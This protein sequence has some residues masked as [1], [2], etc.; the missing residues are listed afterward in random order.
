MT[1]SGYLSV[2]RI[3]NG[4]TTVTVRLELRLPAELLPDGSPW[5]SFLFGPVVL[6]N[7]PGSTASEALRLPTNV[8]GMS[9]PGRFSPWP[10]RRW[11]PHLMAQY[12]YSCPHPT[13]N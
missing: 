6:A 11:W 7:G 1:G 3:W 9:P 10:E 13:S 8:W 2:R 12:S 4:T 5:V